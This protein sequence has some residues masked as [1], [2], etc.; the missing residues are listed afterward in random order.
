MY[1]ICYTIKMRVVP[2]SKQAQKSHPT[3]YYHCAL[4]KVRLTG[5]GRAIA[6]FRLRLT[7]AGGF[8]PIRYIRDFDFNSEATSRHA[9]VQSKSEPAAKLKRG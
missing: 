3:F 6:L 2:S 5:G 7:R 1:A 4:S 8:G 9:P